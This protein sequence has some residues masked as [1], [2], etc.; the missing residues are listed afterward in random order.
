MHSRS[1]RRPSRR[2]FRKA[3]TRSQATVS[4]SCQSLAWQSWPGE[5]E[6]WNGEAQG[7][8]L[9]FISRRGT[10]SRPWSVGSL[11]LCLMT[12]TLQRRGQ[13]TLYGRSTTRPTPVSVGRAGVTH[14]LGVGASRDLLVSTA[15]S[16]RLEATHAY[17]DLLSGSGQ[18]VGSP[19]KR[20]SDVGVFQENPIGV[21]DVG[22]K[23]KKE[24]PRS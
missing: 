22:R 17:S 5:T 1:P 4:P 2:R 8:V 6:R 10:W 16:G 11:R 20:V 9:G 21:W 12:L 23:G 13:A 3:R 15:T 7:W 19:G 18:G 14:K 24:G